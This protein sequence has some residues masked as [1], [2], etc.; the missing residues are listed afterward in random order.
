MGKAM[1]RQ[2]FVSSLVVAIAFLEA[3]AAN[4][5]PESVSALE[6]QAQ[7]EF[8]KVGAAVRER[9]DREAAGDVIGAHIAAQDAEAH[10][11]RFLDIKRAISHL[12]SPS[13]ASPSV[14]ASRN[15][16]SPDAAFL[17]SSASPIRDAPRMIGRQETV[18]RAEYPSWD[19][20]RPHELQDRARTRGADQHPESPAMPASVALGSARDMYSNGVTK[21]TAGD[22]AAA[23]TDLPASNSPGEPPREPFLVYRERLA[24]RDNRE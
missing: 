5:L 17:A 21:P 16:F 13:L 1:V 12:Q 7:A 4:A 11:Y 3:A 15:P 18:V 22:R 20:Y 2:R 14:E 24:G 9:L 23:P 6:S 8:A 19:M 10:R